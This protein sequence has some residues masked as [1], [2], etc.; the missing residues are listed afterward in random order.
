MNNLKILKILIGKESNDKT[1]NTN[2]WG[3]NVHKENYH[4]AI[5]N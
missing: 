1:A 4:I 5:S 2:K 3:E